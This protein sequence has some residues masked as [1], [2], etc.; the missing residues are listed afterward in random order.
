[1][2]WKPSHW[3]AHHVHIHKIQSDSKLVP[4]DGK[5]HDVE[6]GMRSENL[7]KKVLEL[8]MPLDSKDI[9]YNYNKV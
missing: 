4:G 8:E 2:A 6:I 5:Y 1:M 3:K 9:A 7:T